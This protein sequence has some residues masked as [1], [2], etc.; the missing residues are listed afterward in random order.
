M[1]R[2][3]IELPSYVDNIHLV[4]YN[5]SGKAPGTRDDGSKYNKEELLARASTVIKQVAAEFELPLEDSKEESLN[6]F[7]FFFFFFIYSSYPAYPAKLRPESMAGVPD[8]P[9]YQ[10]ETLHVDKRN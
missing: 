7:F 10:A 8:S 2:T 3:D 6:I 9:G 1:T 4:I 5:W